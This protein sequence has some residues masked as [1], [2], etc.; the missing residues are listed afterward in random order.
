MRIFERSAWWRDKE[1]L[2]KE[3]ASTMD[4]EVTPA[5]GSCRMRELRGRGL[6]R[7]QERDPRSTS[8]DDH[9]STKGRHTERVMPPSTLMFCPVM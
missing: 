8:Y 3:S 2:S 1:L 9:A 6:R 7:M 4:F 5:A